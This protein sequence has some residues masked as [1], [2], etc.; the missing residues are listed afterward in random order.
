MHRSSHTVPVSGYCQLKSGD[1]QSVEEKK[2]K[3]LGEIEIVYDIRARLVDERNSLEGVWSQSVH[4]QFE[5]GKAKMGT[6]NIDKD[7]NQ[8]RDPFIFFYPM[9]QDW[10]EYSSGVQWVWL[11]S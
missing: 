7:A 8:L 10:V 3:L 11:C 5:C 4:T 9:M 2:I 1:S 6:A